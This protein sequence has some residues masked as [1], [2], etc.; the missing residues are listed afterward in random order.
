MIAGLLFNSTGEAT[1]NTN[2]RRRR[3]LLGLFCVVL[4]LGVLTAAAGAVVY[5]NQAS[6]QAV[7]SH[8]VTSVAIQ[9]TSANPQNHIPP[10]TENVADADKAERLYDALLAL[11]TM[12]PGTYSCPADFGLAYHLTFYNGSE[13]VGTAVVKPEGCRAATLPDGSV[14]W[15]ATDPEFWQTFATTAGVPESDLFIVPL[16]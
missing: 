14:R 11:P 12:P 4:F 16:R 2:M 9:R 8:R 5:S 13:T 1:V 7:V 6:H 15:S 10:F 3:Y